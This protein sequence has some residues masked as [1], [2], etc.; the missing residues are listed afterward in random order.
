MIGSG[1]TACFTETFDWQQPGLVAMIIAVL[2]YCGGPILF[3]LLRFRTTSDTLRMD[4]IFSAVFALFLLLFWQGVLSLPW[5][6]VS[7]WY[8]GA[9]MLT[10]VSSVFKQKKSPAF[11]ISAAV[12]PA[13]FAFLYFRISELVRMD[14]LSAPLALSINGTSH[15]MPVTRMTGYAIIMA[16]GIVIF[17]L[18]LR[19]LTGYF[20]SPEI[21]A[22][23]IAGLLI[24]FAIGE[25]T[26]L[27]AA[28]GFGRHHDSPVEWRYGGENELLGGSATRLTDGTI[29]EMIRAVSLKDSGTEAQTS[30]VVLL[31]EPLYDWQ[32][33][34]MPKI[35]RTLPTQFGE[36]AFIVDSAGANY[37][38]AG[39]FGTVYPTKARV[40]WK[41]LA[42]RDWLQWLIYRN[43][44]AAPVAVSFWVPFQLM[45]GE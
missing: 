22:G 24:L 45:T 41:T 37:G 27:M 10:D 13:V 8:Y 26:D 36:T 23:L 32:L 43:A 40:D 33:R 15:L 12:I 1:L 20:E 11:L 39:F 9:D 19:I 42:V 6:A 14:S 25:M 35:T 30:G 17:L 3:S 21:Y 16:I 28:A 2:L 29:F 7:A 18:I 31:D 38:D 44:D 5:L 34:N 4:M